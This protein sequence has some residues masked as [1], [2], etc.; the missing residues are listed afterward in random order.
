MMICADCCPMVLELFKGGWVL[1][2]PFEGWYSTGG[3][4]ETI[5]NKLKKY[6]ANFI[7]KEIIPLSICSVFS[8]SLQWHF[9]WFL[10]SSNCWVS[11]LIQLL[12]TILLQWFSYSFLFYSHFKW[13]LAEDEHVLRFII[14]SWILW[15]K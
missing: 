14:V 8:Y 11:L 10:V 3:T 15:W 9:S 1:I 5:I 6:A 2:P 13:L 4:N 7:S 12:S